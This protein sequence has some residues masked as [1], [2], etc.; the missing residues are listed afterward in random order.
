MSEINEVGSESV[1]AIQNHSPV[2]KITEEFCHHC[3]LFF[4]RQPINKYFSVQPLSSLLRVMLENCAFFSK[5]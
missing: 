1:I 5:Y 2:R 3:C 4:L